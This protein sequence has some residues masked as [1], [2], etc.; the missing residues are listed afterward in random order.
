MSQ[1]EWGSGLVRGWVLER[2]PGGAERTIRAALLAGLLAELREEEARALLEE[3]PEAEPRRSKPP[4]EVWRDEL[5]PGVPAW[6]WILSN[7]SV[8][9]AVALARADGYTVTLA[10]A[11][12]ITGR[13]FGNVCRET[14]AGRISTWTAMSGEG[15]PVVFE[16]CR[17]EGAPLPWP[18]LWR[19]CRDDPARSRLP[20]DEKI[21][22]PCGQ[23]SCEAED[24]AEC[25]HKT[26]EEAM[27]VVGDVPW[28]KGVKKP[29][30]LEELPFGGWA[31][32]T[33]SASYD[34]P[35]DWGPWDPVPDFGACAGGEPEPDP[36]KPA[37]RVLEVKVADSVGVTD[38]VKAEKPPKPE[39]EASLLYTCAG[40]LAPGLKKGQTI[41]DKATG[42]RRCGTCHRLDRW[43]RDDGDDAPSTCPKHGCKMVGNPPT[44]T[45][46]PMTGKKTR[47]PGGRPPFCHP[48]E[49]E[50][51]KES[52]TAGDATFPPAGETDP[53]DDG[54]DAAGSAGGDP[55]RGSSDEGEASDSEGEEERRGAVICGP[56]QSTIHCEA[57]ST[58]GV[59]VR[60]SSPAMCPEMAS[61]WEEPPSM[62]LICGT[63]ADGKPGC[64]WT[65][66]RPLGPVPLGCPKCKKAVLTASIPLPDKPTQE[67][68]G[69]NPDADAEPDAPPWE[70]E[71]EAAGRAEGE[72]GASWSV[73][74]PACRS[75]AITGS[76]PEHGGACRS[77][78]FRSPMVKLCSD[79]EPV[80]FDWPRFFA[81]HCGDVVILGLPQN[82]V[83]CRNAIGNGVY[84]Y[85]APDNPT[86]T[87]HRH[88]V[89]EA[90]GYALTMIREAKLST[91]PPRDVQLRCSVCA[92]NMVERD[93]C[94]LHG[95]GRVAHP[96]CVDGK[97]VEPHLSENDPRDPCEW[98]PRADRGAQAGD[99]WHAPAEVLVG[100]GS[101][102]AR[103][104][105]SC[106]RLKP[107]SRKRKERP[108]GAK[109]PAGGA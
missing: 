70:Q 79:P 7:L 19:L 37:G 52:G 24:A 32:S 27:G 101:K 2:N 89:E 43:E 74:C 97:A 67:G 86:S 106:R 109:Q 49:E 85:Q 40:C 72:A 33:C 12:A 94:Y 91:V 54:G 75:N 3:D 59:E 23:P 9:I 26:L 98:N 50:K 17:W 8:R 77:C 31:C 18:Q 90:L 55:A 96:V 104:C 100:S 107:W 41:K 4:A 56:G 68:P 102:S 103:L 76:H 108:L 39:R 6:Q 48:C 22:R 47:D 25:G 82:C 21:G 10:E 83:V 30:Q 60:H 71:D 44:I 36:E 81:R 46:D 34:A 99:P 28:D 42:L 13:R 93:A 45:S 20:L 62:A 51:R 15:E 11:G 58:Q 66:V 57:C 80:K 78:G 16:R 73:S 1:P 38:Q 87:A 65:D 84:V 61:T 95:N 64:G 63:Q 88:C 53:G 92:V 35:E 69:P 105:W 14:I 29:H 5:S